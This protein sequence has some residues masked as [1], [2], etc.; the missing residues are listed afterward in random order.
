ME[1]FRINLVIVLSILLNCKM[2]Q[3]VAIFHQMEGISV[4][5]IK[6]EYLRYFNFMIM[7]E[8]ISKLNVLNYLILIEN[9]LCNV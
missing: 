7:M 3:K 8:N 5:V 6:M 4:W 2:K 1:I 9:I